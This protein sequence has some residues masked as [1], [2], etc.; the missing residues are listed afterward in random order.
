[1]RKFRL[2]KADEIECRISQVTDNGVTVLLY[3]TAR[4]D[5]ALLDETVGMMNWQN[6]YAVIDGKMYCG[7]GIRMDAAADWVWKWNCGTESNTEAE[8]GQ[9]SD[10]M[11]RAGFAWGIGTELYSAPFIYIGNEY[12]RKR[13]GKKVYDKFFVKNIGYNDAEDIEALVIINH[14]GETVYTFGKTTEKVNAKPN[15][16]APQA[17]QS[18]PKP[19][20]KATYPAKQ[21]A[22][23][24]EPDGERCNSC[25]EIIKNKNVVDYSVK[26]YGVPLCYD[27]QREYAR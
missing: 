15:Q 23:T 9:A 13:D 27:C 17:T 24:S 16:N 10:A 20:A 7:I 4:T 8:K 6:Q 1:M 19:Q 21:N 22:P 14:K 25:G 12:L 26:K 2:L 11:K 5:Y 3:K 18:A